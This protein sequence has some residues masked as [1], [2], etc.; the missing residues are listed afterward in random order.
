[1]ANWLPELK[2][3]IK[4]NRL[5]TKEAASQIDIPV[6]TLQS[7]LT[8]GKSHYEPSAANQE[9]I[10]RFLHGDTQ[11]ELQV[12]G[13][14]SSSS[15]TGVVEAGK[16]NDEYQVESAKT[17]NRGKTIR[18]PIQE[19]IE[20]NPLEVEV[21]DTADFQ[22]LRYIK[23]LGASSFV[24]PGATHTRFEHSLGT[25]AVAQKMIDAI[26]RNPENQVP[27]DDDVR[28]LIR[29]CALLHD[30]THTPFGHTL[31]DE[32]FLYGKH[33]ELGESN[34]F[35]L[36][37]GPQSE[38]G[39]R[40]GNSENG[41]N[42]R[43]QV[44]EYL[45]T[46]DGQAGLREHPY[47]IDIVGNTVCAD[48]IDYLA[49]D[50]YYSGLRETFDPRFLR[51]LLIASYANPDSRRSDENRENRLVL[52]LLK[53]KRIRRDVISEVLHLLRLRYSLAEKVYYH[54]A[55][56][57]ISAMVIEAVQ[58]AKLDKPGDFSEGNLCNLKFGDE[59]LLLK[60]RDSGVPIATKLVQKISARALYKPVYLLTY[61]TP[62]PTDTSWEIKAAIIERFR[63]QPEER[64]DMERR[65]E[66]WNNLP[67][68]SLIIYCPT[69]E[70]SL[71]QVETLCLW[72]HGQIRKLIDVPGEKIAME[73]R[74]VNEAH[75]ELW[76]LYVLLE[77]RLP[78]EFETMQNV[79]SD[80]YQ[81]FGLPNAIEELQ[82][83]GSPPLARFIEDWAKNQTDLGVT[84]SEKDRL[85]GLR[86]IYTERATDFPP[87][88]DE[89]RRDL[90]DL[91][92]TSE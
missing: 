71:K 44:V 73:A 82:Q 64:F 37:L 22:R 36:F 19:D 79:A 14:S 89:L 4:E 47:V 53:N 23:Q 6:K 24:F 39:R 88:P 92:K 29:M 9:R 49:R 1:M 11:S 12:G 75:Q 50:T 61:S 77:R 46:K 30:I 21:I 58:A 83:V 86:S 87:S 52:S 27:I 28:K 81:E 60:L 15:R 68:G 25:L 57:I 31:E 45:T 91:R 26:N 84:V 90:E 40:I 42:F 48:L 54:H 66:K 10:R 17:I 3:Y 76:K 62:S 2:A 20:L 65:L 8:E 16:S 56:V 33:D 5:S 59:E 63:K 34:R 85:I 32:G 70:M 38:I 35:E 67:L 41:E 69:G 13:G 7:W 51:S 74:R 80:C 72:R 18:D 55:K 78:R 43:Q